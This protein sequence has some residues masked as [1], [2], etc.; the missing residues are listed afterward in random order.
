MGCSVKIRQRGRPG[1][2][3]HLATVRWSRGPGSPLRRGWCPGAQV[4]PGSSFHP[5][6]PT[7][8]GPPGGGS[9][10]P[11]I[12]RPVYMVVFY[13]TGL[14]MPGRRNCV[15]FI[16][17]ALPDL[18]QQVA[19]SRCTRTHTNKGAH[20]ADSEPGSEARPAGRRALRLSAS[21]SYTHSYLPPCVSCTHTPEPPSSSPNQLSPDS[22]SYLRLF[23]QWRRKAKDSL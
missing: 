17:V 5:L 6:A 15:S 11:E 9:A 10:A 23:A 19:L 2:L 8:P 14:R 20:A 12:Q 4:T 3:S 13:P 7:G 18:I 21:L 1:L 16:P 22:V